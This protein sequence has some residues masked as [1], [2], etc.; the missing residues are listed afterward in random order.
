[1]IKLCECGCGTPAPLAVQTDNKNGRKAGQPQRF[2]KG[3]ASRVPLEVRFWKNI[4]LAIITL[5]E[6]FWQKVDKNGPIPVHCPELGNCWEWNGSKGIIGHGV[7][8]VGRVGKIATHVSLFL[9]TGKWPKLD[10]CH[11]CD[12]PPC[13]RPDHLFEGTDADNRRDAAK[14]GRLPRGETSVGAKLTEDKVRIIR[15]K[16][17]EGATYRSLGK[18][19]GVHSVTVLAVVHRKTWRHVQ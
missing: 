5:E 16:A 8:R 17:A 13:T 19:F 7:I 6:R 14:K 12:Y 3:H 4:D 15:Q 11:K 10:V 1:M 18:E 9:H 2:L